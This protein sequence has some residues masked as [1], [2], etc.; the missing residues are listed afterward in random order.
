MLRYTSVASLVGFELSGWSCLFLYDCF[1][2]DQINFDLDQ[3][4][5]VTFT[6]GPFHMWTIGLTHIFQRPIRSQLGQ[7]N[8]WIAC[9]SEKTALAIL[10]C[11]WEDRSS[12][13]RFAT[14]ITWV[15]NTSCKTDIMSLGKT[16][17]DLAISFHLV[18]KMLVSI[19]SYSLKRA[20]ILGKATH[21]ARLLIS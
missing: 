6:I 14:T 5:G 15:I 13:A 7:N 9:D 3:I 8:H 18:D 11:S 10:A 21:E 17:N 2:A 4:G 12:P 16:L 19:W 1:T 20:E